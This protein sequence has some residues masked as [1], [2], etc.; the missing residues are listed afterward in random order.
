MRKSSIELIRII[1]IT[2]IV[3][4]HVTM[5]LEALGVSTFI[6]AYSSKTL[7]AATTNP[8]VFTLMIFRTFG[9]WGNML[10]F[11][12]SAFF[13]SRDN[14]HWNTEKEIRLL[15]ESWMISIVCLIG[16][17]SFIDTNIG[18]SQ[19]IKSLLPNY[20][21]NNWYITCYLLFYPI[22]PLLNRL[23]GSLS[24]REHFS[25]ALIGFILY[26]CFGYLKEDSFFM[27]RI[28]Q[29]VVLYVVWVYLWKYM[30]QLC[31]NR[32]IN[33]KLLVISIIASVAILFIYDVLSLRFTILDGHVD[34]W[35]T[36]ANPLIA[37]GVF[38][39]MNLC[40]LGTFRSNIVNRIS[41]HSLYIY[42]L[43]ENILFRVMPRRMFINTISKT[44]D[45][46]SPVV[47]VSV[48]SFLILCICLACSCLIMLLTN[49]LIKRLSGKLSA[50][51]QSLVECVYGF[52]RE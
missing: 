49:S 6:D 44:F 27:S 48:C 43:H 11:C 19:I 45:I 31:A 47:L 1:A 16:Y 41:Q 17:M 52:C 3:I 23:I 12:C 10:F 29:W 33:M 18:M 25:Y 9:A 46:S 21:C 40:V 24:R 42:L 14:S 51:T 4:N 2:L 34:H 38:A 35:F 28:V 36:N 50:V 26:Y 13:L 5:T 20:F 7:C 15:I 37:V 22:H 39:S 30:P 32:S 8:Q